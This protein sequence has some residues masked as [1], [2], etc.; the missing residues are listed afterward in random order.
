V[1]VPVGYQAGAHSGQATTSTMG[2]ARGWP[3]GHPFEKRVGV[4]S[5]GTEQ[6]WPLGFIVGMQAGP[7]IT[8]GTAATVP[9]SHGDTDG[10]EQARKSKRKSPPPD[11][12][13]RPNPP[14]KPNFGGLPSP[15]RQCRVPTKGKPTS[16]HMQPQ[17]PTD[18]HPFT[19]T[20]K[21]WKHGIE[22]DC[23]PDW[24]WDVIKVAV[25]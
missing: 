17:L 24:A 21:E 18:V 6:G 23:G 15:H 1:G 8:R 4:P 22:V 14:L 10:R 5:K 19:P 7:S 20:L 11:G 3:V 13:G 16:L 9:Q 2:T 25:M 12:F